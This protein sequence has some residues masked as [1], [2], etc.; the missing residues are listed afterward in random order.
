M[1]ITNPE[2][3]KILLEDPLNIVPNL[4]KGKNFIYWQD[5][6]YYLRDNVSQ[7]MIKSSYL[8]LNDAV[9]KIPNE[10]QNDNLLNKYLDD[11]DILLLGLTDEN[12]AKIQLLG[13][14]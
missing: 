9:K 13:N 10:L 6:A 14:N 2:H 1:L 4:L 8:I 7:E 3:A 11:I 5:K 12:F